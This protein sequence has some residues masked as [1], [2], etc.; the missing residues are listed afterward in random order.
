MEELKI[1]WNKYKGAI[2]GSVVS[3]IILVLKLESLIIGLVLISVGAFVGNY[4][5]AN[6]DEVK[7]K[8]KKL[9]DRM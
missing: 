8:I 3:I 5:Q 7:L 6:K 2:I 9:I 1:F 4:I